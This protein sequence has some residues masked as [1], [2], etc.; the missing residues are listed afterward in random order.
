MPT[1]AL[2]D[3]LADRLL[4][5]G[6]DYGGAFG[7]TV[8]GS[9]QLLLSGTPTWQGTFA[10]NETHGSLVYDSAHNRALQYGGFVDQVGPTTNQTWTIDLSGF[11]SQS[12]F[13]PT[14]EALA[15]LFDQSAVFDPL[16]NQVVV[17]GGEGA[18]FEPAVSAGTRALLLPFYQFPNPPPDSHYDWIA[19]GS[20]TPPAGRYGHSAIRDADHDR[21]IAFGGNTFMRLCGS[22]RRGAPPGGGAWSQPYLGDELGRYEHTAIYDGPRHA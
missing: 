20:G 18:G 14:A 5:V 6:G 9:A 17:F 3:P 4:I 2:Y 8:I 10:T 19:F 22:K 15:G 11:P 21:M 1:R 13:V 7:F 12:R 16:R